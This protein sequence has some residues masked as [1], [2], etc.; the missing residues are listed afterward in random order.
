MS[1]DDDEN[2]LE[3][4]QIFLPGERKAQA[5]PA[6]SAKDDTGVLLKPAKTAVDSTKK[7]ASNTTTG[8][9]PAVKPAPASSSSNVTGIVVVLA[10]I[11]AIGYFLLR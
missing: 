7:A 11:A 8:Q 9:R 5:A 6:P 1:D 2:D 4:T 3:K 10:V